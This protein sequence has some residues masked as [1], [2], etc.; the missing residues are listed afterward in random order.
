MRTVF[1]QLSKHK[2]VL[3]SVAQ[4]LIFFAKYYFF[5]IAMPSKKSIVDEGDDE[6]L[7]IKINEDY[8]KKYEDRKK[9]EELTKCNEHLSFMIDILSERTI[10]RCSN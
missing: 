5:L 7:N 10:W 6:S 8:A 1:P 2:E 4:L 9:R 3:V